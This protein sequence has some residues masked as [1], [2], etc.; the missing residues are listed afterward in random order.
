[1]TFWQCNVLHTT[2]AISKQADCQALKVLLL[3]MAIIVVGRF[4][5][6]LSEGHNHLV[7]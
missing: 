2:A 1:M 4:D 5:N 6:A 7:Q 3:N